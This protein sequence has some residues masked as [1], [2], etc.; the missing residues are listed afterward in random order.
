MPQLWPTLTFLENVAIVNYSL[1]QGTFA[2]DSRHYFLKSPSEDFIDTLLGANQA[3]EGTWHPSWAERGMIP[4]IKDVR[5]LLNRR[6]SQKYVD[7]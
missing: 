2:S 3:P 7:M 5:Y 6:F 1:K 4:N